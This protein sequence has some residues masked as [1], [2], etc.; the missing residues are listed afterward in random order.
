MG[1]FNRRERR[2]RRKNNMKS[3]IKLGDKVKDRISGFQGT[4]IAITDWLNGCRRLTVAPNELKDGK[5]I[6]SDTF[7]V[8]DLEL[9]QKSPAMEKVDRGGPT[10]HPKR[11]VDPR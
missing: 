9:Q 2:E 1:F 6:E 3:N 4:V 11:A 8:Q 10:I 7:D 5:R